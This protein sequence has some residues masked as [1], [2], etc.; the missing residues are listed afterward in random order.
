MK[1]EANRNSGRRL[2]AYI[3]HPTDPLVISV[4]R[5]NSQYTVNL[6][7]RHN[8]P[9]SNESNIPVWKYFQSKSINDHNK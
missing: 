1:P 9:Q 3:L 2:V 4:I 6:H 7:F 5:S 8:N